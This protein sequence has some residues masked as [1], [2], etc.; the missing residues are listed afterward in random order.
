MISKCQ[1]CDYQRETPLNTNIL[2]LMQD[3]PG[4]DYMLWI[5]RLLKDN[6]LRDYNSVK[7]HMGR[8]HKEQTYKYIQPYHILDDTERELINKRERIYT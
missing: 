4:E 2:Y 3:V 7:I 1:F 5:E 6:G 8:M